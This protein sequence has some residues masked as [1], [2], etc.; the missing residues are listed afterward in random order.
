MLGILTVLVVAALL[1]I[2][3]DAAIRHGLVRSAWPWLIVGSAALVTYGFVVNTRRTIDFNRLMG[4]YIAV[5]F[6]VSQVVA[7]AAFGERPSTAL[8][9]G[10]VLIVA[11][12]LV[13][14]V[15]T[16]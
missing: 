13:I 12:G 1:E 9:V 14:Q 4:G 15:G 8:V 5:F 7:W 2:G 6:V 16:S 3:G 10:G 11:G